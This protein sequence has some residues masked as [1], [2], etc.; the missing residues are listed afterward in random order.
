MDADFSHKPEDVPRL[1]KALV[2]S[3]F[4]YRQS[5][6]SAAW[7]IPQEW[8]VIRKLASRWCNIVAR[9]VVGLYHIKDCTAGFRHPRYPP[10]L[11]PSTLGRPQ[12]AGVCLS[13]SLTARSNLCTRRHPEIPVAFIDRVKGQSKLLVY[14]ILSNLYPPCLVD[15][16]RHFPH[17]Y[18]GLFLA[19]ASQ[20]YRRCVSSSSSPDAL[21]PPPMAPLQS[22]VVMPMLCQASV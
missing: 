21:Q 20:A 22:A 15:S 2:P 17:L 9:Y 12:R 11:R 1:I 3:G 16:S 6:W 13:D 10:C 8:H 4:C 5:L 19:L 14:A 7:S 18:R